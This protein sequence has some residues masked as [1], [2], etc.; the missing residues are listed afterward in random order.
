MNR[1][2]DLPVFA[3]IK[4]HVHDK[5]MAA[6]DGS[7][8]GSVLYTRGMYAAVLAV[9]AAKTA[10]E[11]HGTADINASQMRDGMEALEMT[12]AKMDAL[13]VP[14]IGPEFSVS[15]ADHGGS[16]MGIVQQWDAAAGA[17]QPLTDYITPDDEVTAPLVMADSEAFAAENNIA[18]RCE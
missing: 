6:G 7:N 2:A 17:W 5:G 12:A 13:G 14:G 16:G 8:L 9:E 11:L 1:I 4:T 3:D 18:T 10:Q 15:C